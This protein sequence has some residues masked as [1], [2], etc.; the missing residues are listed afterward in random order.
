MSGGKS[1]VLGTWNFLLPFVTFEGLGE[2]GGELQIHLL[3]WMEF[4][5]QYYAHLLIIQV[6]SQAVKTSSRLISGHHRSDC[7]VKAL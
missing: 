5:R 2:L 1:S 6:S 7:S 3:S 4:S